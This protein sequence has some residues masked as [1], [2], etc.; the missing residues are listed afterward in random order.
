MVAETQPHGGSLEK[1]N[2]NVETVIDDNVLTSAASKSVRFRIAKP[3]GYAPSE[4]DDFIANIVQPS[5]DWYTQIIH[6]RDKVVHFLGEELDRAETDIFN[7]KSQI[8]F[9][10]YNSKIEEGISRNTDDKEMVAL[11][12]RLSA[13]EAEAERLKEE[14]ANTTQS[15]PTDADVRIQEIQQKYNDLQTQYHEEVSELQA[16]L[17]E[18]PEP[19]ASPETEQYIQQVTDQYNELLARYTEDT[20]ALQAQIDTLVSEATNNESVAPVATDTSELEQ[21]IQQITDQYNELLA[22]YTEDTQALQA[23]VETLQATPS[24]APSSGESSTAELEQYIQQITDQYNELLARYTEDTQALQAELA[25]TSGTSSNPSGELD[26]DT[27]NYIEQITEQYNTLLAQ[28]NELLE[29]GENAPV[30]TDN[31]EEVA[32]LRSELEKSR[33]YAESLDEHI[34]LLEKKLSGG[35][36]EIQDKPVEPKRLPLSTEESSRPIVPSDKYKN[37]P[38]GIRPDDLE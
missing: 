3:S 21:Y 15:T 28:Y 16:K 29:R 37:L 13:T 9:I 31:S 14:L 1:R 19:S 35:E 22:R 32:A 17:A 34:T 18:T 5:I 7:L 36:E 38:P 26:S 11:M 12:E 30:S 10:E 27:A 23:Q 25:A 20:Q 33:S 4:V 6:S 24:V 2:I 8:Q